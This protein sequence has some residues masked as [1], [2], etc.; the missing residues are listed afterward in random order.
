VCAFTHSVRE[1]T[2]LPKIEAGSHLQGEFNNDKKPHYTED[3]T[4]RFFYLG[5]FGI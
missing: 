1:N 5:G 2:L 3:Q 4:E